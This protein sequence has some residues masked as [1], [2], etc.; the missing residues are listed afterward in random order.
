[1]TNICMY[2]PSPSNIY[3]RTPDIPDVTVQGNQDD[4]DDFKFDFDF[5]FDKDKKME[6]PS[7]SWV[8]SI[9][10][11]AIASAASSFAANPLHYRPCCLLQ[12]QDENFGP[13]SP[14]PP[15]LLT[16]KT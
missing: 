5:D 12:V 2:N 7:S 9:V 16:Q 6:T 11:D 10:A 8:Y 1:M 15:P 14:C 4:N 13:P 3:L